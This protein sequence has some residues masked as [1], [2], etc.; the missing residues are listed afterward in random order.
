MP[1]ETKTE[2]ADD[3]RGRR[4]RAFSL[5]ARGSGYDLR[6]KGVD[7][8]VGYFWGPAKSQIYAV[9]PRLVE[10]GHATVKRVS[11]DQR[12]DKSVYRLNASRAAPR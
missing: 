7:I 4:A 3:D 1:V 12:P 11:Q 8:G 5:T 9:P 6:K 2:R 10:R